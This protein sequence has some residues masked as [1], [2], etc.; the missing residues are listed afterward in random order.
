M[1]ADRLL[2]ILMLLQTRPRLTAQQL[3]AELEVSKR[4]IYRDID[5]LCAAGVP[6]Y[7]DHGRGGGYALLDSYRTDL[8]GLTEDE[9]QALFMLSVPAPLT[10]LG[11]GQRLKAALLKLAAA[12]PAA[13]RHDEQHV[14]HR[15]HLDSEAWSQPREPVPHLQTIHRAVW[16]DRRLH[17]TYQLPFETRAEW[18]VDPYGLVAKGPTWYLVC[19]RDDQ[20]RVH[21]LAHVLDARVSDETFERPPGFDLAAFWEEWC[22]GVEARRPVYTVTARVSPELRSVLPQHFGQEILPATAQAG[23]PDENG[24]I[25]LDLPFE[26][27]EN[28]RERLL[29]YGRA[30][31]V[32]RPRALRW[33]ILDFARQVVDLY[34]E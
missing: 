25:A 3:A 32:L 15:V 31:E 30:V 8:T 11:V 28:A 27:L 13:R 24:W 20:V 6:I 4:T 33:S 26:S 12:L 16:L 7:A 1:R 14:R 2:S 10:E 17:L 18:T 29:S 21:R 23:R 9:T 22:A 5:A 19:A 34:G